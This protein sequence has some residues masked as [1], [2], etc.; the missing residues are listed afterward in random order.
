MNKITTIICTIINEIS[1]IDDNINIFLKNK[2]FYEYKYTL[3]IL[4]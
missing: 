1:F 3:R 2:L 4:V